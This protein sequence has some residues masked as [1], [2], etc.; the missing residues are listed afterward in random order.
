VRSSSNCRWGSQRVR[1]ERSCKIRA[2]SPARI[3]KARDGRLPVAEDPQGFGRVEPFGQRRQDPC[4]LLR[5]GFQPVR[6]GMASCTERG[7]TGLTTERLDSLGSAMLAIPDERVN[8]SIG[9]AEVRA[10]L[11]GT[12]EA[13]GGYSPGGSSA[14]FHLTPGANKPRSR[15]HTR[16]RSGGETAGRAIQWGA[17]LI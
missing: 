11:I 6:W 2:C 9:D 12:S 8:V 13:C 14:A 4:D 15:S 1:K 16:R 7:A 5:R 10:L 17:G 3:R